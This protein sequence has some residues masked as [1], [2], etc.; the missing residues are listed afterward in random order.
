MNDC[1]LMLSILYGHNISDGESVAL[2]VEMNIGSKTKKRVVLP[3]RPEL[4]TVDQ[5]LEDIHKAAPDDP[6]FSILDKT[7][8]EQKS[9][10]FGSDPLTGRLDVL[11]LAWPWPADSEAELRFQQ[12]RHYLDLNG[13]LEEALGRLQKQRETLQTAGEQLDRTVEE[14][15]GGATGGIGV[16]RVLFFTRVDRTQEEEEE[17]LGFYWCWVTFSGEVLGGAHGLPAQVAHHVVHRGLMAEEDGP[18]H[19]VHFLEADFHE[20]LLFNPSQRSHIQ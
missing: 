5:L 9:C 4:P 8:Q 19:F 14:V 16:T 15:K 18:N 7:E 2:L 1:R 12:S 20:L 3:S 17:R 13:R 6:V 10:V 11:C